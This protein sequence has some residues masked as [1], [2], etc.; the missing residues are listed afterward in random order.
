MAAT[1]KRAAGAEAALRGKPWTAGTVRAAA[2]ALQQDFAPIDDMR[3]SAAYRRRAA[4]ALLER[5]HAETA[6][7]AP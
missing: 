6:G 2:D 4:A 5:F 3:A 1:P 7:A